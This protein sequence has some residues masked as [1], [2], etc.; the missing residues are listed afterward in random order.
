MHHYFAGH[1]YG[2]VRVD[3]RGTGD[4]D[5]IL[6]DEY[7]EQELADGLEVIRWLATQPW[8]SGAVGMIGKSWGG[9]NGLQI[10]AL[11]PPE[12]KAV[13]TV[14][15]SDDRYADDAHYMGG[16]LLNENLKWGSALFTLNALPPDPELVDGSWR[17]QWLERLD[18]NSLFPEM[19]LRHQRRD[20]YWKHGSVCEDYASISC[21]VYAVGGWADAYSN[22][23][24][25]LLSE[26]RCPKK[27]LIGPWAHLY[28]HSGVP[29]PAIGF[30]QEALAWWDYWLAGVDNGIMQE[31][32]Y[33]VW[34][35]DSVAPRVFYDERPGRWI[36]EAS[37]PSADLRPKRY[38]FGEAALLETAPPPSETASFSV[39]SPQ[40]TGLDAGVWCPFGA[41]GDLPGDQRD[42]D[43]KSLVFDSEPLRGACEILGAPVVEVRVVSDRP[44]AMLAARIN[45]VAPDGSSARVSYGLLNLTHRLSHDQPSPLEPGRELTARV[46]LNDVAHR[47]V[48]GHKIRLALSTSYWPIAWPSPEPVTL[49]IRAAGSHLEIPIRA[50]R[51]A[52]R[53]LEPFAPPESGPEA[54]T[55]DLDEHDVSWSISEEPGTHRILTHAT[56]GLRQDGEPSMTRIEPLE[57]ELG[58]ATQEVFGIAENDPLSATGEIRHTVVSRR[59]DWSIR[60]ET[61]VALS[62]TLEHFRVEAE[63]DAFEGGRRV[64]SRS[65]DVSVPR[66]LV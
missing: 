23:I 46:R 19:W 43:V 28:P 10:A 59:N 44:V 51:S 61:Q 3:V 22:A 49:A 45:D 65:F 1:G 62:A 14:C 41:D 55:V 26:L 2:A 56:T 47:F 36:A 29:G 8:C 39:R 50:P 9:F 52:D 5:G 58:H 27:G 25:R 37:W 57:L 32:L 48:A 4:S 66:D 53:L 15:A 33:R 11:A 60:V 54:E 34:M 18:N 38:F 30:L 35:Q 63:L 13:I 24:P 21:A 64:F 6:L 40:T 16:C 12:L 7:H 42:D 31:P 20:S 17:D